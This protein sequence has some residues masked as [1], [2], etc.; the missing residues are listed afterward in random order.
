[1][2]FNGYNIGNITPICL[3]MIVTFSPISSKSNVYNPYASH[4]SSK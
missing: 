3:A 4:K 1:M 2:V